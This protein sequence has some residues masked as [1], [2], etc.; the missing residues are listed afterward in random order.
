M[1]P[2]YVGLLLLAACALYS[3]V[4]LPTQAGGGRGKPVQ[5]VY[6]PDLYGVVCYQ[7]DRNSW[8]DPLSCV[9]VQ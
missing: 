5:L 6:G 2:L 8:A 4:A 1:K 3:L 9:K 7:Q